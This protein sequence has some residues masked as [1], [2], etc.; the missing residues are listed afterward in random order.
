MDNYK[1]K[2]KK[3]RK[4]KGISGAQLAQRI[5]ISQSFFSQLENQKFDIKVS[6]LL[7]IGRT[8]DIC[9]Y[10]LINICIKCPNNRALFFNHCAC[11]TVCSNPHYL[12]NELWGG[13]VNEKTTVY[14]EPNLKE[15]VQIQLLREREKKSLS[16]LVNE[17]LVT[18]LKEQK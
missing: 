3:I 6:L 13:N 17:L 8:L 11:I 18:W 14:I 4:K 7:K 12:Y 10:K 16:A 15:S 9:P 1:L 2:I 5:G